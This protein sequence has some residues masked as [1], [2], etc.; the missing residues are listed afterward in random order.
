MGGPQVNWLDYA[1]WAASA[2]FWSWLLYVVT[3]RLF[4]HWELSLLLDMPRR[5]R[6]PEQNARLDEILDCLGVGKIN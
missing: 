5:D 3:K 1:F 4:L 6:T 2:V